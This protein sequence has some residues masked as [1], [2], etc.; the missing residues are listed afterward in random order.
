MGDV[1]QA[2]T[3]LLTDDDGNWFLAYSGDDPQGKMQVGI[4]G[5]GLPGFLTVGGARYDYAKY[6]ASGDRHIYVRADNQDSKSNASNTGPSTV[7][8]SGRG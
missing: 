7:G 6:D 5:R 8:L 3:P 1:E 4:V 2:K